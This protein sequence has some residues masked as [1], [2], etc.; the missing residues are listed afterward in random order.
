[1]TSCIVCKHVL[2]RRR[3][4]T[5]GRAP[6]DRDRNPLSVSDLERLLVGVALEHAGRRIGGLVVEKPGEDGVIAHAGVGQRDEV[7]AQTR[8]LGGNVVG[9]RLGQRR[10]NRLDRQLTNAIDGVEGLG[11]RAIGL[12]E[13]GVAA[14]QVAVELLD[15]ALGRL[16]RRSAARRADRRS[17]D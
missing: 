7:I 6:R 14:R 17:G 16:E 11:E 4:V 5:E 3:A 13:E 10:G 9:I 12:L 1:M 8:H 15:L 2:R